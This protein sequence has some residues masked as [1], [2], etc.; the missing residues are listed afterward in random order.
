MFVSE[1]TELGSI[2]W[3]LADEFY[4]VPCSE[5]SEPI[6]KNLHVAC[7]IWKKII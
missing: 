2:G 5:E 7:I 6:Q 1:P 3:F 4:R